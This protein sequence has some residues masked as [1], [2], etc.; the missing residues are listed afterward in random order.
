M[1]FERVAIFG[2]TSAI[3]Q[4]VARRLARPGA[5]LRLVARDAA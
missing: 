4:S 5:H 1:S 3:A 2:A